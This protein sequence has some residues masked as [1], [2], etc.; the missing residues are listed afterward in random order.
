MTAMSTSGSAVVS[1]PSDTEILITR[2]FDAPRH[3]VFRAWTTP[4]LIRR[5]WSGD[6]GEVTSIE[7]DLRPGGRWRYVMIANAGF[8]VAFRGEYHEIVP[9]ERIVSTEIFEPMPDAGALTT[10]TFEEKDA[11]T[12]VSI[13]VQHRNKENRDAHV[14]SGMEDGLQ[15]A[16]NYLEQVARS[17]S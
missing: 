12:R 5:W 16:L 11:R 7:V 15:E 8:E 10:T 13:L 9:S 3:L 17:L 2:D 1:L 6:R 4:E 14:A